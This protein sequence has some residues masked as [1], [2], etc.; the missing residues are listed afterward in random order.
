MAKDVVGEDAKSLADSLNDGDVMILENVRFHKEETANDE[1]FSKALASLA[2]VFCK[3]CFLVLL[4]GH[5]LQ[6]QALQ[7]F[8]LLFA[9]T[10]FKR[11][12]L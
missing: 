12:T 7:L 1:E 6:Q 10:L 3:R 9:D 4:T 8:F 2:D 5:T 11:A